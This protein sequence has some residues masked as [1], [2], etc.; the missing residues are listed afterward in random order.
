MDPPNL[1]KAKT[2]SCSCATCKYGTG[3]GSGHIEYVK[4]IR[5]GTKH[6]DLTSEKICDDWEMDIFKVM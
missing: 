2:R 4:C 3:Y 1:R 5:Y 6:G